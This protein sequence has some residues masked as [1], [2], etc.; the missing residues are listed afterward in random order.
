M[1]FNAFFNNNSDSIKIFMCNA[2][3]QKKSDNIKQFRVKPGGSLVN[4]TSLSNFLYKLLL[5]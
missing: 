2:L 5:L 4:Y 3:Q 1:D